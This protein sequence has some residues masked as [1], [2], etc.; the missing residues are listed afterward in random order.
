MGYVTR[1]NGST[2]VD[3]DGDGL[4]DGLEDANRDGR[5]Q[6]TEQNPLHLTPMGMDSQTA[7]KIKTQMVFVDAQKPTRV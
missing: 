6:G 7:K 4:P 5:H 2:R 3:S 1:R